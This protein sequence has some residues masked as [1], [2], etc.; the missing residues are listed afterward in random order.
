[1][2]SSGDH[3]SMPQLAEII[4]QGN[5][6][7][8]KRV[9]YYSEQRGYSR[10][11]PAIDSVWQKSVAGLSDGLV[12]ALHFSAEIPELSPDLDFATDKIASFGIEEAIKH[13]HR[14]ISLEKFLGM[15][16]YFRQSYLDLIED[17]GESPS[18]SRWAHIYVERYFDRIELGFISE[19]ER[20]SNQLNTRQ[21]LLLLTRN[22]ELETANIRLQQEVAERINAEKLIKQL[23]VA[24][25]RRVSERTQQL[26]MLAEQNN[27][28]LKELALLNRLSSINLST[29]RLNK[30]MHLILA[31]L[32]SEPPSFFDRA[33]LFLVNEKSE[34]LQGML[35]IAREPSEILDADNSFDTQWIISD[36]E[37][38]MQ[39]ETE[40]SRKVRSCR[41]ELAKG[42]DLLSRAIS[43]KKIL[44]I[45]QPVAGEELNREIIEL[46]G[47]A[48]LAIIPLVGDGRV[49]GLVIVD[50]PQTGREIS[51]HDLRFL[52]LFAN[53]AGVA[54][55][56]L[57][58]CTS[59]EEANRRL[60]EAQEQLIHGERLATIGEMAAGIAHELKG[61]MVSI[62]GFARRL[63][64]KVPKDSPEAE[65]VATIIEEEQRLEK[66]ISD[67]LSFS[68]KTTICYDICSIS[69][70]VESALMIVTHILHKSN[71]RVIKSFP[72]KPIFLYGDSQQLKQVFINLF[73]NAQD[74]MKRGGELRIGISAARIGRGKGVSVKVS[75]TGE[76]L[77]SCA[78]NSIFNPF[79][80]TKTNG[81]GLGL[82]IASRIVSNHGGKLSA[83]NNPDKGA[84]FV[85]LLPRRD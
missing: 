18:F 42:K 34:F 73:Y 40:F 63:A 50:N 41:I 68:K 12:R 69:E 53:H 64:R 17:S 57:M 54:I 72:K 33:M 71:I 7:L 81:T 61:P 38:S 14:G 67:I 29:V 37:M 66:M 30:L 23:N 56:N 28:K 47:L 5:E 75:D 52:H 4:T 24:L 27:F 39:L 15:I 3:M 62:G 80:T 35:G 10:Y 78:I 31:L 44:R 83:G 85:V 77:P 76:G 48:S 13:R 58:L 49:I 26:E 65:Y 21:E 82:P 20:S 22:A 79:F 59:L 74:V 6:W 19:W 25:E 36:E 51:R 11:T 16:K 9:V 43:E 55:E 32:T 8:V 70:I 60:H 2:L 46:L 84:M 1:M 45:S